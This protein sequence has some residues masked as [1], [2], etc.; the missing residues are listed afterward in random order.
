R[1]GERSRAL[2]F[3]RYPAC[4]RRARAMPSLRIEAPVARTWL[5]PQN[6]RRRMGEA[7]LSEVRVDRNAG[8][9]QGRASQQHGSEKEGAEGGMRNTAPP[10]DRRFFGA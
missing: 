1:H 10:T 6:T 9:G 5:Q 4:S 8:S 7:N 2:Y 3:S